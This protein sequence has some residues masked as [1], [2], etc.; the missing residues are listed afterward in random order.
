MA[1]PVQAHVPLIRL[2]ALG[3]LDRQDEQDKK[4]ESRGTGSGLAR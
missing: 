3:N 2:V 1:Y 4:P